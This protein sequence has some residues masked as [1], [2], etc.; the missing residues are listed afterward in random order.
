MDNIQEKPIKR[1]TDDI[2]IKD[3]SPKDK[4]IKKKRKC[5]VKYQEISKDIRI[6][7]SNINYNTPTLIEYK[8]I[9]FKIS[10]RDYFDKKE[11]T[12]KCQYYRRIK[13]K[14]LEQTN[15]GFGTIKG[16]KNILDNTF[17]YYLKEDHSQICKNLCSDKNKNPKYN[18]PEININEE[19]NINSEETIDDLDNTFLKDRFIKCKNAE[20]IDK[21]ILEICKQ[22]KNYLSNLSKFENNFKAFYEEKKN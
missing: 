7:N 8:G 22:N 16:I 15:F 1:K 20:E 5:K 4:T 12:W 19:N 18:S 6:N 17:N 21:L 11:I 2:D 14:P 10:T 9:K 3:K 13:D